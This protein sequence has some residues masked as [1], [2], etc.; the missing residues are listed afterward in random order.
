MGLNVIEKYMA[1]AVSYVEAAQLS[2][3][4]FK[5]K[6]KER[7]IVLAQLGIKFVNIIV[8][9]IILAELDEEIDFNGEHGLTIYDQKQSISRELTKLQ[10]RL[11]PISEASEGQSINKFVEDYRDIPRGDVAAIFSTYNRMLKNLADND[12][13]NNIANE[14]ANLIWKWYEA[15]IITKYSHVPKFNYDMFRIRRIIHSIVIV[16]GYYHEKGKLDVF[17]NMFDTWFS[18]LSISPRSHTWIAPFEVYD[19]E[20]NLDVN[21]A[22]SFANLTSV[23]LWDILLDNGLQA[24]CDTKPHNEVYPRDDEIIDLISNT[25]DSILD[26]YVNYKENPEILKK[27]RLI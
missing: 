4:K 26:P 10:D 2:G 11:N 14:C 1:K 19:L 6:T 18:E 16:F 27:L 5:Q 22:N 24:L 21:F 13:G 25:N 20:R 12:C 15:R 17:L 3:T 23:V 7:F 8:D 9:M